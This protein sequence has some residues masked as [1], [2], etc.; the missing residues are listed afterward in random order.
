M[1]TPSPS[2]CSPLIRPSLSDTIRQDILIR[3]DDDLGLS[4]GLTLVALARHYRVSLTPVPQAVRDLVADGVLRKRGNGRIEL[5]PSRERRPQR[6]SRRSVPPPSDLAS[7]LAAEVIRKSLLGE[8]DYLREESTAARFQ[9]GRTAIRQAFGLLAGRGL[10]VHVR[11]CGWRVRLFDAAELRAY[12]EIREA[13]ELKALDLA[14]PH[15]VAED[16]R[17]ML[18]GNAASGLDNE[19][20]RYLV[21]RSGN[22]YIRDFFERHGGYYTSLFDFAAPETR[23]VERMSAQHCEILDALIVADWPRARRAL[24]AHIRAQLPIVEALLRR[25]GRANHGETES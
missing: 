24:S 4:G 25:V 19:L 14:R 5:N 20:H 18:G 15:L 23:D 11:R 6:T 9:V 21:E 2:E 16:L 10:I 17:R 3:A 12:L 13:L 1:S 8:G 22:E 7:T